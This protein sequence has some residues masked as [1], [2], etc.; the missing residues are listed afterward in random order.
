MNKYIF[1]SFLFIIFVVCIFVIEKGADHHRKPASEPLELSGTWKLLHPVGNVAQYLV[2]VGAS[3]GR[4]GAEGFSCAYNKQLKVPQSRQRLEE[5]WCAGAVYDTGEVVIHPLKH[6][7]PVFVGRLDEAFLLRGTLYINDG[8]SEDKYHAYP[9]V[10][11][12]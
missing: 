3:V 4:E 11:K 2:V 7:E 10:L 8:E 12:R 9:V 1:L 6:V 5:P